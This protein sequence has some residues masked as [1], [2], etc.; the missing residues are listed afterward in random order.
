MA[1]VSEFDTPVL[2]PLSTLSAALTEKNLFYGASGNASRQLLCPLQVGD[3]SEGSVSVVSFLPVA[4]GRRAAVRAHVEG[5]LR[6]HPDGSRGRPGAHRAGV[7]TGGPAPHAL[8]P[9]VLEG[10]QEAARAP[11]WSADLV[12][13]EPDCLSSDLQ[14][15]ADD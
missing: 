5:Q 13:V 2:L 14:H 9:V 4:G 3:C 11:L 15:G 6:S 12:S 1:P 7:E 8:R 10:L